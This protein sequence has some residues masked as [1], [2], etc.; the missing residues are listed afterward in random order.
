MRAKFATRPVRHVI[1]LTLAVSVAMVG[2]SVPLIASDDGAAS[3][4]GILTLF[5]QR[6]SELSGATGTRVLAAWLD[7]TG[8]QISGTAVDVDGQPLV[9]YPVMLARPERGRLTTNTAARGTFSFAG[10]GPGRYEV[11][12][13]VDEEVVAT[14]GAM[15]LI[16]GTMQV[17]DIVLTRPREDA[18]ADGGGLGL[19][20]A[21]A[22][23][24]AVGFGVVL[25]FFSAT[26]GRPCEPSGVPSD[27]CR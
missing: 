24:A 1:A 8:G 10:L 18:D 14:S 7:Q 5:G 11:Q 23:G 26:A 3:P 20:A 25:L 9:G 22:I 27:Q 15:N 17:R 16:E 12:L 21:I 19:G 2:T 13:L 4:T 6:L